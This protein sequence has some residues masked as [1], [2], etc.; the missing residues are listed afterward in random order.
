MYGWALKYCDMPCTNQTSCFII[1]SNQPIQY[2][3]SEL[4]VRDSFC[5]GSL[6]ANLFCTGAQDSQGTLL[7]ETGLVACRSS[8]AL[9]GQA[10]KLTLEQG[11]ETGV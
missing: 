10:L 11:S 3:H 8:W 6:Q 7:Y 9:K 4:L 2:L 5:L 1:M